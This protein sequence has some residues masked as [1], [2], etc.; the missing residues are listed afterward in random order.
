M[1][2]LLPRPLRVSGQELAEKRTRRELGALESQ[3]ADLLQKVDRLEQEKK[4]ASKRHRDETASLKSQLQASRR[5]VASLHKQLQK[6][7]A[8]AQKAQRSGQSGNE[9]KELMEWQKGMG[10]LFTAEVAEHLVH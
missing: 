3:V 2:L 10:L 7:Q 6:S 4:A 9:I 8:A 1:S 5:E